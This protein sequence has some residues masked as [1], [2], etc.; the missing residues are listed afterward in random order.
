MLVLCK[1]TDPC[2][3]YMS[4]SDS[5][6]SPTVSGQSNPLRCDNTLTAGWYRLINM[7]GYV[8]NMLFSPPAEWSCSTHA[9]MWWDGS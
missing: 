1:T 7:Y 9:S 5:W 6:R 2:Y 4:L 8:A 3:S